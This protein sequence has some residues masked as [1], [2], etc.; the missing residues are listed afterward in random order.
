MKNY[1]LYFSMLLLSLVFSCG[2]EGNTGPNPQGRDKYEQLSQEEK[3]YVERFNV[4]AKDIRDFPPKGKDIE[5]Y[6]YVFKSVAKLEDAKIFL[7]GETHTHALNQ[8]WSAG[9][10][11]RLIKAR[12]VVLFEGAQAG[13]KVDNVAEHLA[14]G[15]FAA[16][17][18]E[19]LKAHKTYKQTNRHK[20]N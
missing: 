11:N 18:Y 19:K 16:R 14:T 9:V 6:F 20:Q 4:T 13:T 8:L 15:I 7:F 12:D 10:I 3:D 17:E 2:D 5:S 1:L